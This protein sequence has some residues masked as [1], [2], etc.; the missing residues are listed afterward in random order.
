VIAKTTYN[1]EKLIG[2]S[3][4]L[5]KTFQIG[6]GTGT[7][8]VVLPDLSAANVAT[9][10]IA[11]PASFANEAAVTSYRAD[12]AEALGKITT[13]S[14]DLGLK[15]QIVAV[16]QKLLDTR[17]TNVTAAEGLI[18]NVD[19]AVESSRM[20]RAELL[21]QNAMSSIQY[22]RQYAAFAVRSLFG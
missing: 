7:L 14:G 9:N 5:T 13:A 3:G 16:N 10:S 1:A 19:L 20:A 4:D 8:T 11:A 21:A 17:L 15:Q 2:T 6:D 18:S 12:V 22:T